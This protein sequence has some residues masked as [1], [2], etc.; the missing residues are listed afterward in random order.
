MSLG[1]PEVIDG[2]LQDPRSEELFSDE[3]PAELLAWESSVLDGPV[4]YSPITDGVIGVGVC[5]VNAKILKK[6]CAYELQQIIDESGPRLRR[7]LCRRELDGLRCDLRNR[8]SMLDGPE[9]WE[10]AL[11]RF[12][13]L[14]FYH[15]PNPEQFLTKIVDDATIAELNYEWR[16]REPDLWA[17]AKGVDDQRFEILMNASHLVHKWRN[18]DHV[19][20]FMFE[21]LHKITTSPGRQRNFPDGVLHRLLLPDVHDANLLV[22]IPEVEHN[23]YTEDLMS[24]FVQACAGALADYDEWG[25]PVQFR[26]A[27]EK[28]ERPE[29]PSVFV[30][31][32]PDDRGSVRVLVNEL[33]KLEVPF[34]VDFQQVSGQPWY[35]EL[36]RAV[37]SGAIRSMLVLLRNTG[38]GLHQ[39]VE[40]ERIAA[41]VRPPGK[42]VPVLLPHSTLSPERWPEFLKPHAAELV[43]L[44]SIGPDDAEC[45]AASLRRPVVAP[46]EQLEVERDTRVKIFVSY[47]H[48]DQEFV[49]R[50][51]QRSLVEFL[52]GLENE[53]FEIVVDRERLV[54]GD[55]WSSKLKAELSSCDIV[56]ALV[57]QSFLDS[58]ECLA[59][60]ETGLRLG[61]R[62]VA[63]RTSA[64]SWKTHD[65]M[66]RVEHYPKAADQYVNRLSKAQRQELYSRVR[67]DLH[68]VGDDIR[69]SRGVVSASPIEP[70]TVRVV[71][72]EVPGHA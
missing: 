61:K 58:K 22:L 52:K 66:T 33:R 5:G 70:G 50:G 10:T 37:D 44:Q 2:W 35:P 59:E 23:R 14:A 53:G 72:S 7:I 65:W 57:S 46:P 49:K 43:R 39:E 71:R 31:Y 41:T 16:W 36:Q 64:C 40:L 21:M 3:Y 13:R 34:W 15:F 38:V 11:H 56:L 55:E 47:S 30:A 63:I 18:D 69:R 1:H 60:I 51:S 45:V 20:D 19:L 24:S 27:E 12:R 25:P 68:K 9:L 17:E 29:E 42:V 62:I 8:R 54:G 28:E 26:E 4:Y 67:E 48:A 6:R 32:H